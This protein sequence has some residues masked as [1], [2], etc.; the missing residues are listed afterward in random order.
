MS[1]NPA[2]WFKGKELRPEM[3][4]NLFRYAVLSGPLA[5][6][7]VLM[8]MCSSIRSTDPVIPDVVEEAR[9]I[10]RV[11][12]WGTD[13]ITLWLGG[14]DDGSGTSVE[15][16]QKM[17][18]APGSVDLPRTAYGVRQVDVYADDMVQIGTDEF[19]WRLRASV[20]VIPPGSSRPE[21]MTF[22]FDAAEFEDGFRATAMPRPVSSAS[23]PFVAVSAY[24]ET[25]GKDTRVFTAAENFSAA[26]L[27]PDSTKATLGSTVTSDFEDGPLA[28]SLWTTTEVKSVNF[29]GDSDRFDLNSASTGDSIHALITVKA[30]SSSSTYSIIQM[31]VEMDMLSNGQWAVVG[32]DEMVYVEDIEVE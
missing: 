3:R 30:S 25:A 12:S 4:A 8:S 21:R 19:L 27:T 23:V 9:A 22:T 29:Y 11:T 2:S 18:D 20:L 32:F 31:P 5:L 13:Y 1:L 17:T 10:T 26:Y 15:S 24:G 6:V 7:L 28:R 14:S 16:L